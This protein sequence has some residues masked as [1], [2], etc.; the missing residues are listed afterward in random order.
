ME[1]WTKPLMSGRSRTFGAALESGMADCAVKGTSAME[2][3]RRRA[4]TKTR[5]TYSLDSG[6]THQGESDVTNEWSLSN[7]LATKTNGSDDGLDGD[8]DGDGKVEEVVHS[9]V[10]DGKSASRKEEEGKRKGR[11]KE[12]LDDKGDVLAVE[13]LLTRRR[14]ICER[15]FVVY[16]VAGLILREEVSV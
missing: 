9:Y 4:E 10:E 15:N 14:E 1:D 12:E 13:L 16:V 3:P 5:E 2:V 7:H 11:T 6:N 8:P